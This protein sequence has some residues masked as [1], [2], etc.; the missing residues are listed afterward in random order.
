VRHLLDGRL[1]PS[2]AGAVRW[3]GR[4]DAGRRAASGVYFLSLETG[5]A[6]ATAKVVLLRQIT[7]P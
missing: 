1:F 4:D 7:S 5:T 3:D 2:G 6:T